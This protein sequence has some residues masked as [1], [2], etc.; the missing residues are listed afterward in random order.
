MMIGMMM[1]SA[2]P[3]ILMYARVGRQSKIQGR[4]FVRRAGLPSAIF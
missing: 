1:P 4:P 2:A 3:M